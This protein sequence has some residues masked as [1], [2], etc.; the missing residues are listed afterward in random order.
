MH[1]RRQT[2]TETGNESE[3]NL[4]KRRNRGQER[5]KRHVCASVLP[6]LSVRKR[7]Y[8]S[9]EKWMKT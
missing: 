4:V 3:Q 9:L 1:S 8:G 5:H 7:F 6:I 2:K